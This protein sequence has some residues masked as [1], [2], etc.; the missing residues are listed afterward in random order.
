MLHLTS[1]LLWKKPTNKLFTTR[2]FRF[3]DL[4][5]KKK[6]FN[7]PETFKPVTSGANSSALNITRLKRKWWYLSVFVVGQDKLEEDKKYERAMG[8]A[9]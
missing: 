5:K 8:I 9:E 2:Y 6:R 1:G 3:I 4:V 7:S